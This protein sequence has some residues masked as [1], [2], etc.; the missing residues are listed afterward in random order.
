MRALGYSFEAALADIIDNSLS[1]G[2]R[3][4]DVRFSPHDTPYVAILDDGAGM[5]SEELT[6][7][8]RHGSKDPKDVRATGDL[9]RFGLGLK[10]A[11]LSQCRRLT[12]VSNSGGVVS[13]RCWDLDHIGRRQD[14]M[15]LQLA[16]AQIAELP[17]A[18]DL[19]ALTSGTLVVWHA[20]DRLAAGESSIERA[21]G[22]R[23]D[24][25]RAH[26]SLVFHRF[27]APSVGERPVSITIN[28]NP[29]RPVD[30]FL[31]NHKATQGLPEQEFTVSDDR[32]R[33]A[34]FILPHITKLAA[35]DLELAGGEDGLRRNQG[36]YVYRNRRLISWGSWF[37]LVR[38]EELTKL[39][40]VQ[41][42]ISNRLDHLWKLDIKKSTASPPE[43]LREGLK[44][45]INRITDGSRRVYTFRG[46]KATTDKIVH[47]WDRTIVRDGIAYR[48]NREHPLIAALT[49]APTEQGA[50]LVKELLTVLEQTLPFD[51]IY[52]D[53]ASE[54]RPTA[55]E[56]A[57]EDD[58]LRTLATRI[59]AALGTATAEGQRFLAAIATIEPFSAYPE[60]AKKIALELIS[61]H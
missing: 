45:I 34:P 40:R 24:L 9:G 35:A 29:L 55:P 37:R 16:P 1:A 59:L 8:M 12:V 51:A 49:N 58:G 38:Q 7:A 25:T 36:F 48:I 26:L 18:K 15:L 56:V 6:A 2:A 5:S 53:M 43:A 23:M 54:V 42:D 31:S 61:G 22:D 20:F 21:L 4:I 33:V 39:A 28:N 47:A 30:P 3:A 17:L 19:L 11:S 57:D 27:L 44:Q 52:L 60:E 41:V 50:E 13:G 10:T 46:T 32:V 14:W